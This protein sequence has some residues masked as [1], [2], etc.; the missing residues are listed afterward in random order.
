MWTR[1]EHCRDL[2]NILSPDARHVE[3]DLTQAC[4]E[5]RADLLV[6]ARASSF[7]LVSTAVPLEIEPDRRIPAVVGAVGTGPHSPLVAGLTGL[8]ASGLG[9]DAVLVTVSRSDAE[10]DRA[11]ATLESLDALAPGAATKIVRADTAAGLIDSLPSDALLVLGA[12][13]GSWWQRQFFGPGRRLIHRSQAGSVI[14]KAAPL[15]CFQAMTDIVP[16]GRH[17]R[18]RDA[19]AVMAHP[20]AVVASDGLLVGVVRRAAL[21]GA[22]ADTV[23]TLMEPATGISADDSIDAAADLAEFMDGSPAP[24]VDVEGRLLG[25]IS[26]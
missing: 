4:I 18:A 11:L 15:K 20:V 21:E 25:G 24:V 19:L 2:A 8:I 22:P 26:I 23:G 16:L 13:G 10:D 14:A 3:G 9:A 17:M 12:P 1:G 6:T 7:G 5:A